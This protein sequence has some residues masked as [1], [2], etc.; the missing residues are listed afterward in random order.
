MKISKL[1]NAVSLVAVMLLAACSVDGPP[2]APVH[3]P[4]D[5]TITEGTSLRDQA[6]IRA[7]R[8]SL[9]V[10]RDSVLAAAVLTQD[11]NQA[12]Y[13]LERAAW[14]ASGNEFQLLGLRNLLSS[15]TLLRC[16]PLQ[17]NLA[18]GVIGPAGGTLWVG[19]HKLVIPA[20]ALSQYQLIIATVP[21]GSLVRVQFAPHGL[22]FSQPAQ[23]TMSYSHCAPPGNA[24]FRV[25]YVGSG[26]NIL[27]LPPSIDNRPASKVTGQIDHFSSYMIA[28]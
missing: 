4:L 6:A 20:N 26:M 3:R 22:T 21:M 11:A 24:Q 18:A 10:V 5:G 15:L 9:L 25:A 17:F 16:S 19:P 8:D 28:Y 1:T 7:R 27:E 14:N 12:E 13:A 2:T 23:L